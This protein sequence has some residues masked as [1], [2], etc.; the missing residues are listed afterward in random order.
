MTS[1]FLFLLLGAHALLGVSSAAPPCQRLIPSTRAP[2]ASFGKALAISGNTAI[3]GACQADGEQGDTGSAFVFTFSDG[4]WSQQAKL[5]A[6]DAMPN[7]MFGCSVASSGDRAL[8]AASWAD[9]AN[10][11]NSGVAYVFARNGSSW[12]QEAKLTPSNPSTFKYFGTCAALSSQTAVVGSPYYNT[13][14]VYTK[15]EAGWTQKSMLTSPA[16]KSRDTFGQDVAVS[17]QTIIVA[18]PGGTTAVPRGKAHIYEQTSDTT[19]TLQSSLTCPDFAE[20]DYF[21][22]SV[23]LSGNTAI[24]GAA[25]GGSLARRGLHL[26]ALRRRVDSAGEVGRI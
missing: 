17:G 22:V 13:A 21:A 12:Q 18:A 11:Q 7:D 8:I 4:H 1:H 3:L 16:P 6:A 14:Y 2:N 25:D 26:H 24:I 10:V 5:N 23:A 15:T 20:H 9:G 19:W